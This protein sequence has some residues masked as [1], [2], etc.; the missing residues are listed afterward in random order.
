M[1]PSFNVQFLE[2]ESPSIIEEI[3]SCIQEGA[4]EVLLLLNFLNSGQHVDEDIP[5]IVDEARQRY[6]NTKFRIS[7]P[8]G[9]H[10]NISNL[11]LN[12]IN[13]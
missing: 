13:S 4:K 8:V 1:F 2:I 5:T 12:M 7:T 6:K 3:D 10:P 11:F 9:Q